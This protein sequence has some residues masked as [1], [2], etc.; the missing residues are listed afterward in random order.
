MSTAS[1]LNDFGIPWPDADTGKARDA[2]KAWT[3]IANAATDALSQ[4]SSAAAALSA[5][6]TGPAMDSFNQYWE[7]IGGTPDACTVAGDKAM[8]PVLI[9]ACNA[10]STACTNFADAVDETK[11]KLEETAGEIAAA[12]TAGAV[13]TFFTIGISDAVST[14]ATGALVGTAVGDVALLGT[15]VAEIVG[16]MAVGAVF[17]V[18]DNIM[19]TGLSNG[20]KVDLGEDPEGPG[21]A[22]LSLLDSILIGGLTGGIGTVAT[23]GVKTIAPIALASLPDDVSTVIPNLPAILA[24]LP[25]AT[26]STAGK[27]LIKLSSE[28]AAGNVV[29]GVQGKPTDAPTLQ[30]LMGEIL[31]AKIEGAAEAGGEG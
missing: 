23:D 14:L 7:G 8:L 15:T 6:N 17:G 29:N 22:G 31:N 12:I 2:A 27:V 24:A 5:H 28:Y 30:E 20:I 4:T 11:S 9:E 21:E 18:V 1:I 25:D 10:L 19:E 26:E 16:T 3:A 13:A